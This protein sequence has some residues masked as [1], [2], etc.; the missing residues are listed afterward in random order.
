M[1]LIREDDGTWRVEP[2]DEDRAYIGRSSPSYLEAIPR[3]LTA[4][5]PAFSR[6]RARSEF[7]FLLTLFRI[8]GTQDAGWDP[9]ET[10]LRAIPGIAKVAK[11]IDDFEVRRHLQLWVYGHIVEASEP[12]EILANLID[13]AQGGR[14][15][16]DRFPPIPRKRPQQGT[17]PR[18][19]I[20]PPEARAQTP[21]E[22]IRHLADAAQ[23]AG[24]PEVVMPL[25]EIWDRRL[26]NAIFHA[27]YVLYGSE[28]RL[29]GWPELIYSHEQT[30]TIVDRALVYHEALATLYKSHIESYTEPTEFWTNPEFGHGQPERGVVI[31]RAGHGAVGPDECRPAH[32]RRS[33]EH[34]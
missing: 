5:D 20:D 13:V 25:Q 21:A 28:V 6:A 27:D 8:R 33:Q 30:T 16:L 23:G 29:S 22:K 9:Y 34:G 12:Y 32:G 31:V 15:E 10:T 1:P 11:T 7:Q 24:M 17:D 14:F 19:I 26:R 18:S 2:S 4:L 3:Y